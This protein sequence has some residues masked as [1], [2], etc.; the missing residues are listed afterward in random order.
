MLQTPDC[1]YN[2][3][4]VVPCLTMSVNQIHRRGKRLGKRCFD[5]GKIANTSMSSI[6]DQYHL[7]NCQPLLIIMGHFGLRFIMVNDT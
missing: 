2:G 5:F 7:A 6:I 3:V 1:L 4:R